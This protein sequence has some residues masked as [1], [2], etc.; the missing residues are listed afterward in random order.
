MLSLVVGGAASGKSAYAEA[1][2]LGLEGQRVYVATMEPWDEECVARIARHRER[3]AGFGFETL[4]CPR[5]LCGLE[6]RA[7]ANVLLDCMG[8]LLANELYAPHEQGD[9][10][11]RAPQAVER[12]VAGVRRLAS[13]CKNLTIV[14]NEVCVAGTAYEGDT[15][16][17][18]QALARVNRMVA[19]EADFVCEVVAGLPNVLRACGGAAPGGPPKEGESPC[20]C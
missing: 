17:Y 12:V 10:A 14:S 20:A 13:Q 1:L 8:N 7:H 3:R 18:L 16:P 6:V 11:Q 19:A 9:V 4:E 15:L 5:D 2:V